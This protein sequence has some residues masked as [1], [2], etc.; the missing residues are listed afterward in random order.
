V[1]LAS[2]LTSSDVSV[3]AASWIDTDYLT[4]AQDQVVALTL[5]NANGTFSFVKDEAG[6]WSMAGL[7]VEETLDEGSVSGLVSR[8]ATIRMIE[9]LGREARSEYGLDDPSAVLTVQTLD[10]DGASHTHTLY[11]GARDEERDAYYLKSAEN[12]YYVRVS[13]YTARDW[14]EKTREGFLVIPPTPEPSPT[15]ASGS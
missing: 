11:V 14:V 9:P 2:G 8:S 7:A 5:E 4:V 6:T 3:R 1:Y 12:P 10:A 15:P 13:S